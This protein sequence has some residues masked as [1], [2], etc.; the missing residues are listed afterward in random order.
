MTIRYVWKSVKVISI[1]FYYQRALALTTFISFYRHFIDMASWDADLII[2]KPFHFL[3]AIYLFSGLFHLAWGG[4]PGGGSAAAGALGAGVLLPAASAG[5]APRSALRVDSGREVTAACSPA[6]CG[7]VSPA[8]TEPPAADVCPREVSLP[9]WPG[10]RGLPGGAGGGWPSADPRASGTLEHWAAQSTPP[11]EKYCRHF[12][13]KSAIPNKFKSIT[14]FSYFKSI[15][16]IFNLLIKWH[17]ERCSLVCV[18]EEK[19]N[20]E[21]QYI[22][23]TIKK[24]EYYSVKRID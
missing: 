1:T 16:K 15:R 21:N 17:V 4:A 11:G 10:A 14:W 22:C 18:S 3:R 24:I 7:P 2:Y 19:L 13:K 8:G 9:R 23:H 12:I 5:A 20:Y 6:G